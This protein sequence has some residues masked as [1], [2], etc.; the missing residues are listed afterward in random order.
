MLLSFYMWTQLS[1]SLRSVLDHPYWL[2]QGNAKAFLSALLCYLQSYLMLLEGKVG[3]SIMEFYVMEKHMQSIMSNFTVQSWVSTEIRNNFIVSWPSFP[4]IYV[5][6]IPLWNQ[7]NS[8]GLRAWCSLTILS[9]AFIKD[10][11]PSLQTWLHL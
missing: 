10:T 11:A 8:L 5:C 1:L 4:G 7:P 6:S 3:H 9:A 2:I